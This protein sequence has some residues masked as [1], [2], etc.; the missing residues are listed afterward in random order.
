MHVSRI[1]TYS[2]THLTHRPTHS[3]TYSPT[4][5]CNHSLTHSLTHPLTLFLPQYPPPK[6]Q[7][8]D[9][10]R[11]IKDNDQAR[12]I[13]FL[14]SICYGRSSPG[15]HNKR[16]VRRNQSLVSDILLKQFMQIIM[17][18]RLMPK[19][20][21][22]HGEKLPSRYNVWPKAFAKKVRCLG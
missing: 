21:M 18:L 16:V 14:T 2:C 11:R 12:F 5:S 22:P 20:S 4:H 7:I 3:R 8:T 17:P 6:V 15:D 1:Y 13:S 10:L 19:A 9:L